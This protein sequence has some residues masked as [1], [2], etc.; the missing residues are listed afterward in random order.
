MK[1]KESIPPKKLKSQPTNI[2]KKKKRG[3]RKKKKKFQREQMRRH[4]RTWVLDCPVEFFS[5]QLSPLTVV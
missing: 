1:P 4:H 3:E 5:Y 2:Q